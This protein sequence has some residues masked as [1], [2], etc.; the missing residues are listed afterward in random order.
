MS[1][2][3]P[4]SPHPSVDDGS[5]KPPHKRLRSD[6]GILNRRT[7]SSIT[8]TTTTSSNVTAATSCYFE[9]LLPLISSSAPMTLKELEE[10]ND[11]LVR[12]W[13][14]IDLYKLWDESQPDNPSHE[15]VALKDNLA[16]LSH[17]IANLPAPQEL[18]SPFSTISV[19]TNSIR[20][21]LGHL[22]TVR[23]ALSH[24]DSS[25]YM[26]QVKKLIVQIQ[27]CHQVLAEGAEKRF[28]K[29]FPVEVWNRIFY[30]LDIADPKGY[31]NSWDGVSYLGNF[32]L[33][34]RNIRSCAIAFAQNSL[35][36]R[37]W[38]HR[39]FSL[40][41]SD[42]IH[43][44]RQYCSSQFEYLGSGDFSRDPL[45][46]DS[47]DLVTKLVSYNPNIKAILLENITITAQWFVKIKELTDMRVLILRNVGIDCTLFREQHPFTR[48]VEPMREL[49]RLHQLTGLCLDGVAPT[50]YYPLPN[51]VVDEPSLVREF[52]DE[53]FDFLFDDESQ[54][55]LKNLMFKTPFVSRKTYA[56]MA[57]ATSLQRLETLVFSGR[58][59][60]QCEDVSL[61]LTSLT[62]L[63]KVLLV[64][65]N[66]VNRTAL[67]NTAEITTLFDLAI[68]DSHVTCTRKSVGK[69]SAQITM[70]T[71]FSKK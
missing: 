71:N 55:R 64:N 23:T 20:Q 54:L 31:L 57:K 7:L 44:T 66:N 9:W 12:D 2:L 51:N 58:C 34:S 43:F 47:H 29:E 14:A 3:P 61:L 49:A 41:F 25:P 24:A 69:P 39:L 68:E 46:P 15:V 11:N 26:M 45:A 36:A 67:L 63:K 50:N 70:K 4:V 65:C 42:M 30:F 8:T 19:P 38:T 1:Y 37:R 59:P 35:K 22:T 10:A 16:R 53:A 40:S 60:L 17:R 21:F 52:G 48:D 62:N 6:T 18:L 32:T 13:R 33:L 5:S 28:M 27:K 56:K